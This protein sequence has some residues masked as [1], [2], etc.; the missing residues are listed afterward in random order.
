M[1]RQLSSN[2]LTSVLN[3]I[4]NTG[5]QADQIEGVEENKETASSVEDRTQGRSSRAN[6][7]DGSKNKQNQLQIPIS[8]QQSFVKHNKREN[9]GSTR[10]SCEKLVENNRGESAR[11]QLLNMQQQYK[12]HAPISRE[13]SQKNINSRQS[14]IPMPLAKAIAD[15]SQNGKLDEN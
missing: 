10:G 3:T 12:M 11:Q 4:N 13:S 8:E 9:G 6:M 7:K 5:P 15:G 14:G 1:L 2:K